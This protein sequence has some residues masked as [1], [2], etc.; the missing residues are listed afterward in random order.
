MSREL[1]FLFHHRV[2]IGLDF[3]SVIIHCNSQE[4]FMRAKYFFVI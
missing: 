3:F 1:F 2:L 4:A